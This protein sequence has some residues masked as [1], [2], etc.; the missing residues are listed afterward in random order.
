MT[1]TA[2]TLLCRERQ[3]TQWTHL[4]PPPNVKF[5]QNFRERKI[6]TENNMTEHLLCH[7]LFALRY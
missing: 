1:R 5:S 7:Q 6:D 2:N 4:K 3:L